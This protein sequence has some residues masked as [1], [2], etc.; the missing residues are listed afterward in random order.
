M[1]WWLGTIADRP[2][3]GFSARLRCTSWRTHPDE[4]SGEV[5]LDLT[6]RQEPVGTR[7]LPRESGITDDASPQ[8]QL[9]TR[10][11][12][13]PTPS[14]GCSKQSRRTVFG[15]TG[16]VVVYSPFAHG[17]FAGPR[18]PRG[19]VLEDIAARH[20]ATERQVALQFLVRRPSSFTIPKA[21]SAGHAA[22][23]AGAG[24]LRLTDAELA[25]IDLAFPLGPRPRTL[26]MLEAR[27]RLRGRCTTSR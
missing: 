20:G 3:W 25:R 8:P 7:V 17:N 24:A 4:N 12:H 1:E 2:A 27:R 6:R 15:S 26:P 10:S 11:G 16:A 19:R 9:P 13:E 21:S 22:D 18:A 23:N 14:V 5:P